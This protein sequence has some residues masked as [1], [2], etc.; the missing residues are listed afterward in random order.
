MKIKLSP[1]LRNTLSGL[2][3]TTIGIILTF[4]TRT[5]VENYKS[6]ETE[7]I[8]I[9]KLLQEMDR[10]ANYFENVAEQLKTKQQLLM[11]GL[12]LYPNGIAQGDTTKIDSLFQQLGNIN[13]NI[14]DNTVEQLYI[15]SNVAWGSGQDDALMGFVGSYF[16]VSNRIY[17]KIEETNARCLDMLLDVRLS[18]E[19]MKL[20]TDDSS[21]NLRTAL[22]ILLDDVE[23]RKFI[24]MFNYTVGSVRTSAQMIRGIMKQ[25][26][27]LRGLTKEDLYE[28]ADSDTLGVQYKDDTSF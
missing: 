10:T 14:R 11:Y 22:R 17:D 23:V 25:Y 9:K 21:T 27:E 19:Y 12:S 15:N 5:A 3:G 1:W 2:V 7:K 16:N 13:L 28:P 6:H 4:G 18:D 8:A 20:E 24:L 26:M